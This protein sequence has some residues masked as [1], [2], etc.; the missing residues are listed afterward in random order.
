MRSEWEDELA[1]N[2]L[3]FVQPK[4]TETTEGG[5]ELSGLRN[6]RSTR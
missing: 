6:E 5:G 3:G 1:R 2:G 4:S